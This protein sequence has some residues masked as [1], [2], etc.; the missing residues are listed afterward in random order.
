M[1]GTQELLVIAF[2]AILIF[3]PSQVPKMGRAA[4]ETIRELRGL[5]KDLKRK[6]HDD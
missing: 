1:I 3:G 2:I 4:G 6:V 5:G